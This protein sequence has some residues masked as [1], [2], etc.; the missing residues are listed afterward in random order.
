MIHRLFLKFREQ[1]FVETR[2]LVF[3]YIRG[4]FYWP[5]FKSF[6]QVRGRLR[7]TK[8]F[9][10]IKVAKK[11]KFYPDARLA[12]IGSFD[13]PAEICIGEGSSIGDRSEIH[14]AGQVLI[15]RRVFISWDCVIMDRDYH[16]IDGN[17]EIIKPV[18]IHDDVLIGCRSIILKGVTIGK[19]AVI[20]SGAVVT[21]D[22]PE[23]AIVAGNPAKIIRMRQQTHGS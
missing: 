8:R 12:C 16:G 1:G 18:I 21:K 23:Y 22:V 19:N 7:I 10:S 11:V 17:A 20:G 4:I 3:A 2:M 9:A 13:K 6:I 15:G 14:S 5:R